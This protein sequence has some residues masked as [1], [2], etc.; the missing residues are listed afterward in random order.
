[1]TTRKTTVVEELTID[2]VDG[3]VAGFLEQELKQ[4]EGNSG[5]IVGE[6]DECLEQ[7]P[8]EGNDSL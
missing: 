1:M 6:A 3:D 4:N 5:E 7:K 2:D 8:E